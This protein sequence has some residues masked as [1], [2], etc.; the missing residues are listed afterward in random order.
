MYS[1][2]FFF[3]FFYFIFRVNSRL[4]TLLCIYLTAVSYSTLS[5]FHTEKTVHEGVAA[6]WVYEVS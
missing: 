2:C 5:H 3:D 1:F 6:V 4:P